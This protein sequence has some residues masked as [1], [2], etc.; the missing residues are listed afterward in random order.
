MLM[1]G[2]PLLYPAIAIP[3]QFLVTADGHTFGGDIRVGDLTGNGQADFLVYRC[4]H[5][6]MKPCFMGAFDMQGN[7]LW[8]AGAGGEQP[9]R[10]MSVAIHDIDGDGNTEVICFWHVP[11]IEA[12]ETSLADVVVQIR[13]G[14]T[15]EVKRQA[16][17]VEITSRAGE[18][19]NW[20]HQRL[21]VA[22]L[23][24]KSM[25]QDFIVKLGDTVVA[26]DDSLNVLWTYHSAW[27]EYMNCPA[28]IPSVGDLNGDG[29]DEVNGGYFLLAADG[30]P[31]WEGNIGKAMDSVAITEWDNGRI[32]AICSGWGH[33]LDAK[34]NVVLRLGPE[35][36]PHGQEVRVA[37]FLDDLPGPEMVI[38]WNGHNTDVRVVSSATG[39]L[40]SEFQVNPSPINVGMEAVYWNGP[41]NAA[42]LHNGGWLW[43]VQQQTGIEL[44]GLPPP[45]GKAVHRMGWYHCIPANVCGDAREEMVLYDPCAATIYIYTPAPLDEAAFTGYV[46]GPRQCNV[47]LMG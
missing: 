20:V 23:G 7:P 34:G 19:A 47:R 5:G 38:R 36:V 8:S 9:A 13:D 6:G 21:L 27:T 28:Y 26:M 37:N 1:M 45:Q 43:D 24:G 12:D 33:V 22:N 17:P 44:P 46:P 2:T 29:R 35:I 4:A 15:G 10:P 30:T 3:A 14:R 11:G 39:R 31:I 41:D 40:V 18:G 32:R 42:L 16:A 25:P